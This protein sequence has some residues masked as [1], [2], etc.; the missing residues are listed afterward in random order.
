[1]NLFRQFRDWIANT[2]ASERI[3][4]ATGAALAIGVL[5]FLLVPPGNNTN[6]A[7][8]ATGGGS[9]SQG[10]AS[11]ASGGNGSQS[12]AAGSASTGAS[13]AGVPSGAGTA[14]GSSGGSSSGGTSGGSGSSPGASTPAS[15]GSQVVTGSGC[16]SPPG[17]DQGVTSSEIKVAI[18]MVNI[19]GPAANSTFGLE[20]QQAQQAT[21]QDVVNALNASGGIAC[22]KVVPL[23]FT[24]DPVDQSGLEQLCQNVISSGPFFVIDYGAYY[25]FPQIATCYM[26]A[27][28]PFM[29]SSPIPAKEQ[30]EFYPYLYS[31]T[32]AEVLYKDTAFGLKQEGFFS[33]GFKKLGIIYRDCEP[34]FYGEFVGWLNQAGIPSSEMVSHDIGCP[35]SFDTPSD[36]ESAVLTFKEQGVTNVTVLNDNADFSNI[37]TIAGQQNFHPRWGIPDD[38]AVPTSYG[39][40]HPDYAEIPNAL[41]IEGDRYGEEHTPNYPVSSGTAK[42]NAIFAKAGQPP[43]YQQPVGTGGSACDQLWTLQAAV[44]HAPALERSALAAG[45][46]NAGSVDVSYPWGPNN[47]ASNGFTGAH[48]TYADEF[49]RADEFRESCSCWQVMDDTWHPAVQ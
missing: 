36:Q 24:G 42:C 41:A 40:Q 46:V 6:T 29:T 48:I 30:Q 25:T 11:G 7:N 45:L 22:R 28:I 38:G 44:D 16:Q 34:E 49:W 9:N 26:E 23:F 14:G 5:A 19:V 10:A 4:A 20:S 18:I 1:M 31:K 13:S 15:S 43:V 3:A 32:L 33:S 35:T 12:Q 39:S 47:F 21:Y 37:T 2:S 17:S 27:H 8:V